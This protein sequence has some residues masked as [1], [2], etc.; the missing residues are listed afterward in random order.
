MLT[1]TFRVLVNN[2]SKENF[3]WIRKEKQLMFWQFFFIF[4]KSGVK[5]FLKW[6]VNQYPKGTR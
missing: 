5:I 2:S 1:N 4:Y 3:Y 6:I